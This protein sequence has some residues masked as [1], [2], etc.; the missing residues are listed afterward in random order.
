MDYRVM[1]LNDSI[2][3]WINYFGIANA[4]RKLTE[5]DQWIRRRIR[6]CIWKQWKKVKQDIRNLTKLGI[7]K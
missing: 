1:K 5:L 4:K 2:K 3:G 6:A 7:P